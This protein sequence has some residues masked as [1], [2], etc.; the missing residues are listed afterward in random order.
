VDFG[1][2]IFSASPN[3][4]GLEEFVRLRRRIFGETSFSNFKSTLTDANGRFEFKGVAVDHNSEYVALAPHH[5]DC[6]DATSTPVRVLASGRVSIK[7][8]DKTPERGTLIRIK[9]AVRPSHPNTKVRLQQRR[10]GGWETV[11]GARLSRRSKYLFEFEALGPKSQR[12]RVH[13]VGANDN[14]PGTSKELK[15]KLHK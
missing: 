7:A 14:E 1:G 8:N 6:D 11:L 3:C 12:Y 10:G 13:W 15:L 2:Q 9:G 4:D 5:D